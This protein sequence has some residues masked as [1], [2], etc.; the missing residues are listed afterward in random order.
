MKSWSV[1]MQNSMAQQVSTMCL[2]AD[3]SLKNGTTLRF[4]NASQD[5]LF[6]HSTYGWD[7]AVLIP[8][9]SYSHFQLTMV[10]DGQLMT[11]TNPVYGSVRVTIDGYGEIE[12][13][14]PHTAPTWHLDYAT[15]IVSFIGYNPYTN[16]NI[17]TFKCSFNVPYSSS[18]AIMPTDMNVQGNLAVTSVEFTTFIGDDVSLD[19]I[20]RGDFN[21]GRMSAFWVDWT[22]PNLG[23]AY[24]FSDWLVGDIKVRDNKVTIEIRSKTSLLQTQIVELYS[25]TC[26][27]MLGDSRCQVVLS[28]FQ[29]TGTVTS[30][31]TNKRKTFTDTSR[32]ETLD[33][34]SG[35]TI[36]W[37]SGNNNGFIE[38]VA[39]YDHDTK[40][41]TLFRPMP[42]DIV[43]SNSY[44]ATRS[45]DKTL[46]TCVGVFDNA[47][48]FR[49]EPW[50]PQGDSIPFKYGPPAIRKARRGIPWDR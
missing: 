44:K 5:V 2:C 10:V 45:C 47:I 41:F 14:L 22:N 23:K 9:G 3:L 49:G 6:L 29:V 50:V 17:C 33:I 31:G 28:G 8:D 36:E 16:G 35:G 7:T 34:Y 24:I 11:V 21:D 37:T 18:K 42:H 48:N 32:T 39:S 25:K 43:T 27:A 46:D 19:K 15:G 13:D 40:T 38:Q 30:V 26:R 20:R 12:P 4:T 1:D